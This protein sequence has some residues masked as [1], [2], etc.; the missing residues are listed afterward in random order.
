LLRQEVAYQLAECY[1][2]LKDFARAHRALEDYLRLFPEGTKASEAR[3]LLD[4]LEEK[5][6]R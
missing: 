5:G 4:R 3:A 6:W 1:L 2:Q